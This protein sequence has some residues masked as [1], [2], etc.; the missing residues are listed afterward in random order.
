LRPKLE[1][2]LR[3]NRVRFELRTA[4]AE[5]LCYEVKVPPQKTTD[6]LSNMLLSLGPPK[7]IEVQ[8]ETKKDKAA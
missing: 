6:A 1:E 5:E 4:T 7:G 3:R 2:T 8:W